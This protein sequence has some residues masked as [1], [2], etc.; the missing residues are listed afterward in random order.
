MRM[1]KVFACYCTYY[2][3]RTLVLAIELLYI[4]NHFTVLRFV[5]V[6]GI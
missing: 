2:I 6:L 5:S 3:E 4:Q 1:H